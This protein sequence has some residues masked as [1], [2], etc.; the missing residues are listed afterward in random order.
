MSLYRPSRADRRRAAGQRCA[1]CPSRLHHLDVVAV[2]REGATPLYLHIDCARVLAEQAD[3]TET[4][5]ET[6][7]E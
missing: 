6:N 3:Q 2:P 4:T 7:S 5:E 1:A